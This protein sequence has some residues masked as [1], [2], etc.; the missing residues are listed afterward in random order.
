MH[1]M[2]MALAASDVTYLEAPY[3]YGIYI[4]VS[5]VHVY[6]RRA[7]NKNPISYL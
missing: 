5:L 3:G 1:L 2:D 6:R 4:V 7:L